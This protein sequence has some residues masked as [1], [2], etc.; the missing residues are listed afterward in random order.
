MA[1]GVGFVSAVAGLVASARE[2]TRISY[3]YLSD[4]RRAK[5]TRSQYSVE[6]SAFT[7]VLLRAEQAALDAEHLGLLAPQPTNLSAEV[8]DDCHQQLVL[9]RENLEGRTADGRSLT[10]LKSTFLWP[11][12][13]QQ[14]KKHI[15]TLHRFRSI[16]ADYVSAST[17]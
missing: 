16:F 1:E 6:L 14:L 10:R 11:L 7:D 12:E 13:E 2:V 9:L 3:G 8:L 17:L 4:V 15:D 5:R